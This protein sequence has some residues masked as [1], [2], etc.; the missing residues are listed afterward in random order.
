ML[1]AKGIKPFLFI[2]SNS[3]NRGVLWTDVLRGLGYKESEVSLLKRQPNSKVQNLLAQIKLDSTPRKLM[4]L[5]DLYIIAGKC[6]IGLHT[7]NHPILTNCDRET[8][9]KE[10]SD[11]R[12][13]LKGFDYFN[14]LAYPNG[15]YNKIVADV[16]RDKKIRYAFTTSKRYD[17]ESLEMAMPRVCI[18]N[19]ST[20]A[21]VYARLSGLHDMIRLCV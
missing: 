1:N 14:F 10:I 7:A 17:T 12:I 4:S 13:G 5:E 20:K 8:I 21:E 16:C 15:N 2:S 11:N 18:P 6:Q 3:S 9:T 19:E